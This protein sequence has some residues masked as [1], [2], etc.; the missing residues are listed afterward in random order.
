MKEINFKL[1]KEFAINIDNIWDMYD[2]GV[3]VNN[4]NAIET[5]II[6]YFEFWNYD[7]YELEIDYTEIQK[8]AIKCYEKFEEEKEYENGR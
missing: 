2:D 1:I 3:D 6:N 4:I 8:L 5:W 7:A